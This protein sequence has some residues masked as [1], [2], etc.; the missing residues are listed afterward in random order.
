M[1]AENIKYDNIYIAIDLK[2]FYASVECQERKLDPLTTNLVVADA[3]RTE[4]TICLAVSPALKS[5]GIPGRPRL[6]EV[7]QKVNDINGRRLREYRKLKGDAKASF[8]A[9]SVYPEELSADPSLSLDYIT[10]VPRMNRYIE[11]SSKIC[12]IYLKYISREDITVYSIDEV[13]IDV[14]RYLKT[15]R[16]TPRE[17]AMFLIREV[18]QET[19]ITATAGIGTNLYLA[20]VAM[21]IVAK[22]M[23][24]DENG[25][26][27]AEL[28]ELSY[29]RL[30]WEH[31]PLT[32]FW[33]VGP[34]TAKKLEANGMFTM[35]DVARMSLTRE[36]VFV[37][38]ERPKKDESAVRLM[39]NGEELLYR[40]FGVNAE[41]L[42]DHAWGWEPCTVD[43]IKAYRPGS[44]SLGSGQV[45]HEPYTFEKAEVIVMEM[46]EELGYD[47]MSKG[48]VSDR[49][50]LYIGY[51]RE[52]LRSENGRYV[53][54]LTGEKYN[55]GVVR[56]HYGRIR[57]K[58]TGGYASLA[59]PT[60]LSP[61]ISDAAVRIFRSCAD[62][63]LLVRR[64]NIA[65][66]GLY[67][68]EAAKELQEKELSKESYEQLDLFCD[69]EKLDSEKERLRAELLKKQR[70]Q[71]TVLALREKYG[72][73]S[74]LKGTNFREG[75]RG[76]ERNLE[77]G[78]HKG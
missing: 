52:S 46:A 49:I 66:C 54:A 30:L 9:S 16:M 31:T 64:I 61:V 32:D 44:R 78:G 25:V 73:N 33:R 68:E 65:A 14:T 17:I 22:H 2:S 40:L 45:L 4:K 36:N 26:R 41:L 63:S 34:G 18:L 55:G 69:C 74:V 7:I 6:F 35:G 75:A 20:K 67:T 8:S 12:G 23:E 15:Y 72:K 21:D 51:D 39:E 43:A 70:L 77:V 5:F 62:P 10:A 37:R 38:L 59:S 13:F 56:D 47:L 29:R 3:S 57:P 53:S 48:F 28:D 19:G 24:P 58:H 42:T 71:S 11:I 50:E 27:M 60:S 1:N 76:R